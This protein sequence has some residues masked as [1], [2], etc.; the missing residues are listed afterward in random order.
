MFIDSTKLYVKA[1][2][3]GN[4]CVAFRRE[5]YVAAGGPDGGDGGKGG[6]IVI[7]ADTNLNTLESLRY[8]HRLIAKNGED[9]KGAKMYGKSAPDL[10][11]RVPL[12]TLIK[13]AQS[14]LVIQ[15]ISTMEPFVLCKGGK[16][17]WGNRHFATPTRQCPR[18]ARP[19]IPGEEL[20][21]ILEL[22]LIADVGLIGFPNV[23][24]STLLSVVSAAK[25]KIANYH[26]TTIVPHLGVVAI[27]PENSFV[28]LDIPGIIE[29]ASQGLG[30]GLDFLRHAERC[31]L[32]V[33]IVDVSST[34]G[35]DP[36]EDFETIN[37]EL[38]SFSPTLAQLPQIVAASKCDVASEEQINRFRNYIKAKGLP[39]LPFSAATGKGTE[40][41]IA[42][43]F[44]RLSELPPV[45][46][47]EP[48]Y[49]P[50]KD[51]TDFRDHS[52]SIRREDNV[53]FVE[54]NWLLKLMRGIN[55]GEQE[56]LQYF[57]RVL[58]N[59]GVIKALT[60]AGIQEGDTVDIYG[61]EF[62]FVF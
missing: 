20:E 58:T 1:G 43:L 10:V 56:S 8:T 28:M 35:R 6:D 61:F 12:G 11:I 59:A 14:G 44:Q 47:Y 42:L 24:K 5:K 29:G 18:F 50:P 40:E 49:Q 30:M 7:Q 23:G 26:F 4:G 17:G 38:R 48:E 34:E 3:G 52:V 27:D 25:P 57:Q 32:L 60:E 2:N 22:K 9:G 37:Q 15:D 13:D 46:V 19:G 45:R 16:G 54:G 51:D 21:V 62:D 53:F 31:R 39:F 55:F 33:H 36:I 41:L